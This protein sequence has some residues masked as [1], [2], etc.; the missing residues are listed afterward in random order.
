MGVVVFLQVHWSAIVWLVSIPCT[1]VVQGMLLLRR[2][3]I[4]VPARSTHTVEEVA[5]AVGEIIGHGSIK[6]A[7]QMNG[8]VILFVEKP[9]AA[10]C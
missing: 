2:H 6:Y 1:I 5:L 4:K 8:A 10:P 3:G 9:H 7:A